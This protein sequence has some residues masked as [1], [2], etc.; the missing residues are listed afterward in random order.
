MQLLADGG[1]DF[2]ADQPEQIVITPEENEAI[3]RV[4]P[5]NIARRTRI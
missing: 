5:L 2:D 4:H 1:E 3:S